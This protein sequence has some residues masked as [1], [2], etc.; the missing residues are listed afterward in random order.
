MLKKLWSKNSASTMLPRKYLRISINYNLNYRFLIIK[1]QTNFEKVYYP[2]SRFGNFTNIDG[3]MV[4]YNRVNALI[5]PSSVV[6]DVGCGRGAYIEDKVPL[7]KNLRILKGK[8]QKVI[9]I[10]VDKEAQSNPCLDEFRLFDATQW[11]IENESVDLCLSDSVLEHI[12]DPDIFFSECHRVIKPNG[13]LCIRTSNVLS[14]FGLMSKLTPN[15]LH[16]KVLDKIQN[17]RRQE[18]IFPALYRCNT[19]KKIKKMLAKYNFDA[20]VFG[21]EAEP[22]YLSFSRL[23]YYLAVLHQRFAPNLFK[24][25][26]F[27]FAQKIE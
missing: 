5:Q 10:D 19:R 14:Y 11:P 7:R 24:I 1:K 18:D 9:G 27:A 25:A 22:H 13:Y 8:C 6:L 21:Y 2:E 12:P 15:R 20:Y 26:I 4:F 16:A 23:L 17:N 3:T